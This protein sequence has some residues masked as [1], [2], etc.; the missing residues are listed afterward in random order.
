MRNREAFGSED[1]EEGGRCLLSL[2][3]MA[4]V[5]GMFSVWSRLGLVPAIESNEQVADDVYSRKH[6]L[7]LGV[8]LL[9]GWRWSSLARTTR[10]LSWVATVSD[11]SCVGSRITLWTTV[12]LG[13]VAVRPSAMAGR[14]IVEVKA[15][16]GVWER[17][18]GGWWCSA[19]A[20]LESPLVDNTQKGLRITLLL[21]SIESGTFCREQGEVAI[22][23][24]VLWWKYERT[25]ASF[26]VVLDRPLLVYPSSISSSASFYARVGPVLPCVCFFY[27]KSLFSPSTLLFV[28]P[29]FFRAPF[30]ARRAFDPTRSLILAF[31]HVSTLEPLV[32]DGE[33]HPFPPFSSPLPA[34]CHFVQT[35]LDA[36]VHSPRLSCATSAD[37]IF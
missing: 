3:G 24:P 17:P 33:F 27:P 10:T 35:H 2:L 36:T 6:V 29:L 22:V 14:K 19:R 18:L 20:P 32:T 7:E 28:P 25:E 15:Q 4:F 5:T 9:L 26:R 31:H 8:S 21:G 11:P 34:S 13:A 16:I 23:I 1:G 30:T 37:L 12:G